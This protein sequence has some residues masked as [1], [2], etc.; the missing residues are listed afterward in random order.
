MS[1]YVLD[2]NI[3]LGYLREAPYAAYAEKKFNVSDPTNFVVISIVTVAEMYSLAFRLKWGEK[4]KRTLEELI[5]KFPWVDINQDQILN[6]FAE[7][8]AYSLSQH[9]TKKLN[10]SARPMGDNDLWIAA[11]ASALK[12][13]LLTSDHDFDHLDPE[14]LTLRYID[15]TAKP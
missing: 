13:D 11:T 2:T 9:P 1:S 4:K 10:H 6:R 15:Q 14:F 7:I 5:R 3:I 12:A 8:D